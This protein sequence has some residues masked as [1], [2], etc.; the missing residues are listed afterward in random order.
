MTETLGPMVDLDGGH[1]TARMVND[2][3][4]DIQLTKRCSGCPGKPFTIQE[5]ITPYLKKM[6]GA[7]IEVVELTSSYPLNLTRDIDR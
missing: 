3:R 6:L 4:V 1:L 2:H 5:V 7:Q